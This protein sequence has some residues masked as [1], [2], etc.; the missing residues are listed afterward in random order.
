MFG[1]RHGF[2][3]CTGAR[4][5]GGYI[6]DKKSKHDWLKKRTE[7]WERN[8]GTIRKTVGK[9][10]KESYAT[11]VREIQLKWIFIQWVTNNTGDVFAGAEKMFREIFLPHLLFGK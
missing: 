2:K 11:V 6:G 7:T 3:V 4:Y 9:H 5:P 10:P 8:I 1:S